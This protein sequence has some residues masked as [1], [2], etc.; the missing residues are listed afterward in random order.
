MGRLNLR[1]DDSLKEEANELFNEMG[2]DMSTAV[3]MFLTQSVRER[4]VPFVVGEPLENIK[5][6]K[7]A[8]NGEGVTYESVEELMDDLNED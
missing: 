4:R 7:E 6:R 5:A 1:I 8:L 2:I 3:K